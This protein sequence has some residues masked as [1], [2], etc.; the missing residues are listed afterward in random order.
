MTMLQSHITA[1]RIPAMR[2]IML[3]LS[4]L[5][6]TCVV[7]AQIQT[8]VPALKD[9]YKNDFYIGCLLS[10]PHVG[11]PTDSVVTGQGSVI[12]ANGGYLIKYHM[13]S[14]GP[15]NNMK[16][17]YT[18]NLTASAAAYTAASAAAK[19]SIDT[20]PIITF[21]GN[22]IAQLNWAKKQGFTFRGHTLIWHSQTPGTAFFRTGY[23]ATGARLTK[24]KMLERMDNYIGEMIRQL[25]ARWP[26]LLSAFDVLNEV[27]D[28][29]TLQVRKTNNEWWDAI[30]DSTYIME[31]FRSAR[32]YTTLYGELQLK[33]YYN[34][35]N[36]HVAGKADAIVRTIG[37]V[38]QAGLLDGLGMQEHDANASPTADQWI[39]TYNKYYPICSEMAI[40]ELDVSTGSTTPSAAL[41]AAQANQYGQLFKCFVERSYFSGRGKI[42]NV[43]KD[44]LNDTYTFVTTGATSLWDS[45]DQY[46]PAFYAVAAVGAK[47]NQL[48]SLIRK[49]DS[50]KQSTYSKRSWDVLT[51]ALTLAKFY[52][53]TNYSYGISAADGLG[54]AVDTLT[55]ALNALVMSALEARGKYLGNVIGSTTHSNFMT[56]WNQVT[57]ENA[58]KWASVEGTMDQYNWTSVDN[59]YNFAQTNNIPYKHHA[60]VWG[61]QY[62]T[63]MNS[64]DSAHQRAQVEEWIRLA[65]T[66]YP[67]MSMVD[68]VNEAFTTPV[69]FM[70]ALGGT[71]KTGWDW[72]VTAFTWARKYTAPGVKLLLN[73]YSVLQSN[74]IT[75]NYMRLIDTLQVRGLI[76]GVGIQGHYFE[77]KGATYTN[78]PATIEANL[79]RIAAKGLPIYITEFDIN[80][81]VDSLQVQSY[82]TYFPIFWENPAVRGMTLWG[83]TKYEIWKTD[84]WLIDDRGAE[85]SA[86]QWLRQYLVCPKRPVLMT[87][88]DVGDVVCNPRFVWHPS[89]SAKTYRFQL[90][91]TSTFASISIDSTVSDTTLKVNGLAVSTKYYWRVNAVNDKGTSEFSTAKTFTTGTVL[92]VNETE[93]IP[94]EYSLSQNYPNPFNPT[95]RIDYSLANRGYVSLKIFNLLGKEVADVFSGVR[96]AGRYSATFDGSGLSSGVYFYRMQAAGYVETKRLVLMK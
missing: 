79:N 75:D 2:P 80:E 1:S 56:Y 21:N 85:R 53:T 40:T 20:H 35:Y 38:F 73:E 30:G 36:T 33:L 68:V 94:A 41:L 67:K 5:A 28:D 51:G 76:D 63:W 88:A 95:T 72:V 45:R 57:P 19:D 59:I 96:E 43:S 13:N 23:S 12:D 27:I 71:G 10:Y 17:V 42:K 65:S 29:G 26:G 70:N 14:M 86:M 46:K 32:K 78:S 31:A 84:A 52:K 49:A 3:A 48:D 47:F 58:A 18:V 15:G 77:F 25:H 11:F 8:T 82:K 39:A 64:L 22:L 37:P 89:D 61:S 69:S 4:L 24:Q 90:S 91:A 9:V 55:S 93:A 92:G 74:T 81:P 16:P 54:K 7:S 83:Y 87:P 44:G 62:P 66:R 6:V 60:F 50:L 34:D